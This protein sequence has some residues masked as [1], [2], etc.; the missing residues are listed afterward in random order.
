MKKLISILLAITICFSLISP[1]TASAATIKLNKTKLELYQGKTYNLKL[2]GVSG[3][4]HWSSSKKSV[5]TVSSSGKVKAVKEGKAIITAT[6]NKKKYNCTVTVKSNKTADVILAAYITDGSSI[7]DYAKT[8]KKENPDYLDV[9]VYDDKHITV[10]MYE[11]E[12]LSNLKELAE[13]KDELINSMISDDGFNGSIVKMEVDD[14]FQNIKIY[15][16]KDKF[17]EYVP[18]LAVFAF[19]AISDMVQAMNLID[20]DKRACVITIYDNKT[21]DVLFST[22]E[23][24]K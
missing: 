7:K 24:K 21:G 14:L 3:A 18:F 12:R 23:G 8:F 17:G 16:K 10:T 13:K 4:I 20:V 1:C 19:G 9:K 22:E 5:A 15:V 2:T 6:N 11:A